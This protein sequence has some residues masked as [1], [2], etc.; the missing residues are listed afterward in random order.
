MLRASA[1][2]PPTLIH[3]LRAAQLAVSERERS[4]GPSIYVRT[5]R[6]PTSPW[7]PGATMSWVATATRM[8]SFR[9]IIRRGMIPRNPITRPAESSWTRQGRLGSR[10]GLVTNTRPRYAA[11]S[12]GD[13]RSFSLNTW[14]LSATTAGISSGRNARICPLSALAASYGSGNTLLATVVRPPMR[15]YITHVA[16]FTPAA[17]RRLAGPSRF[18]QF[19]GQHLHHVGRDIVQREISLE[20]DISGAIGQLVPSVQLAR[21]RTVQAPVVLI[22]PGDLLVVSANSGGISTGASSTGNTHA[23]RLIVVPPLHEMLMCD[24]ASIQSQRSPRRSRRPALGVHAEPPTDFRER[25]TQSRC[26]RRS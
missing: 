23:R 15:P 18:A 7:L 20:V 12:S 17:I 2:L 24:S 25:G 11:K 22:G 1:M 4:W 9:N 13:W 3:S 14:R 6:L 16:R 21:G 10:K 5:R 19:I 8:T 26:S